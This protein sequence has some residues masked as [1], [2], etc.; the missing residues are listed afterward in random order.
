MSVDLKEAA[1]RM[2]LKKLRERKFSDIQGAATVKS[3]LEKPTVK[4]EQV[5]KPTYGFQMKSAILNIAEKTPTEVDQKPSEQSKEP[6][7]P[8]VQAKT[9]FD[10]FNMFA[11]YRSTSSLAHNLEPYQNDDDYS[12]A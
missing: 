10:K 7:P 5:S 11:R 4:P 1:S 8:S 3:K 2:S 12:Q 9:Q 6:E